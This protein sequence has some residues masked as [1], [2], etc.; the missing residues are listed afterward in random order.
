MRLFILAL[1]AGL[2]LLWPVPVQ[3]TD[4]EIPVLFRSFI[5]GLPPALIQEEERATFIDQETSETGTVLLYID[6][7]DGVKHSISYHFTD[8]RLDKIVIKNEKK[9]LRDQHRLD[10]LMAWNDMISRTYGTPADE[11]M[12]WRPSRDRDKPDRWG[13]A[14]YRGE[15]SITTTW[16]KG[17]TVVT[18]YLGAPRQ[19]YP[20]LTLTYEQ[21]IP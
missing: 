8:N 11:A 12:R 9:Y 2:N 18:T 14:V 6:K 1:I 21:V 15:L 16:Q 17:D 7:I 20:E 10:D 4:A 5:W 19:Y 3:A 13:W